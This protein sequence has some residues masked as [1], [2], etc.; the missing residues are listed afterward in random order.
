MQLAGI[1]PCDIGTFNNVD[2]SSDND[3]DDDYSPTPIY[4]VIQGTQPKT[5]DQ[6]IT[7][8]SKY[9]TYLRPLT[10]DSKHFHRGHPPVY[11]SNN[12]QR[13]NANYQ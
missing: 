8:D 7:L 5:G 1:S 9:F 12:I 2:H 3:E 6:K 13:I 4:N 10:F 11:T